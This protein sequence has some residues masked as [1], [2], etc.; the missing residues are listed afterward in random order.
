MVLCGPYSLGASRQRRSFLI[1]NMMPETTRWSSSQSI[2][3]GSGKYGSI[4]RNCLF[5]NQNRSL[6]AGSSCHKW[7]RSRPA[8]KPKPASCRNLPNESAD[9][10]A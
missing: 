6:M 9:D 4:R 10:I 7:I 8:R 1:T 3:C 2:L 5:D